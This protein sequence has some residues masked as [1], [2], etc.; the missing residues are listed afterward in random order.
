M[1]WMKKGLLFSPD[2]SIWWQQYYGILPT[3]V[4][5]DSNRIRIFFSTTCAERFG[6]VT[7][8]DVEASDPSRILYRH[9]SFILDTGEIGT[10]DDCGVNVSAVYR[11][12]NRWLMYYAGYQRHFRTPYSILSGLAVSSDGVNFERSQ[13]T[14]ILERTS[15]ELHLR[16]APTVLF[17]DGKFQMWYV[18]GNGWRHMEG[19]Q[20]K[21]RLMPTYCL[22][23]A[24]S[25]DGFKWQSIAEPVLL[26]IGDEFGFGRPYVRRTTA[27]YELFYSIR[28]VHKSYRIGYATSRNGRKWER[29]DDAI[30]IDVSSEGWD[31]EMICYPAVIGAGNF[32]YLFYNGNR[33]GETGFGYAILEK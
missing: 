24:T 16:S 19:E 5:L 32:T 6:R 4:H 13:K 2:K 27:E 7:F 17:E 8:I 15:L 12:N 26:P 14:P 31:S 28:T 11:D 30:G 25:K 9:D 23:H 21:D 10:F 22:R 29:K 18:S 20:F 3:P 1:R 33:N